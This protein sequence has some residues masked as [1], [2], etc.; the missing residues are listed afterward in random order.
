LGKASLY[1]HFPSGKAAMAA[2][3]LADVNQWLEM[4]I[5]PMLAIDE[6]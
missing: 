2:V 3:A 4:R 1:H 5:L 6:S